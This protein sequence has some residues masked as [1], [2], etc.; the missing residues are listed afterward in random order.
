VLKP[1]RGVQLNLDDPLASSLRSCWLF[2]DGTGRKVFDYSRNNHI[3]TATDIDWVAGP[4]GVIPKFNGSTSRILV[5]DSSAWKFGSGQFTIIYWIYRNS[6]DT[7]VHIQ[8]FV[9]QT[10]PGWGTFESSDGRIGYFQDFGEININTGANKVPLRTLTQVAFTR[11]A[12]NTRI[13][14]NA[15]EKAIGGVADISDANKDLS[16]GYRNDSGSKF[17]FNGFM[18]QMIVFNRA[19]SARELEQY[20]SL[21]YILSFKDTNPGIFFVPEIILPVCAN[22]TTL[23]DKDGLSMNLSDKDLLSMNFA[24]KDGL[25][26]TIKEL[27]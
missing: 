16:I 18:D 17:P 15:K 6:A 26:S 7:Q 9:G 19:L 8:Y 23:V 12:T 20:L 14:I 24:D 22:N 11:D 1:A 3:G 10:G 13:F 21:P 25:S 27:C 5:P 4:N 2:N